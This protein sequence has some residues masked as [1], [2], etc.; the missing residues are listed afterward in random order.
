MFFLFL[1]EA[2]NDIYL[3]FRFQSL[4]DIA[5]RIAKDDSKIISSSEDPI[6]HQL[7]SSMSSVVAKFNPTSYSEV[8]YEDFLNQLSE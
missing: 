8:K 1:L 4:S 5:Q 7:V 2:S 3:L 6:L